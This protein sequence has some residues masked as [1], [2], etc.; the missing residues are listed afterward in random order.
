[1]IT[2]K[3]QIKTRNE[4]FLELLPKIEHLAKWAFRGC[5]R[6]EREEA[7]AEVV[8]HAWIGFLGLMDRGLEHKVYATPLA[9]FAIKRVRSGRCVGCSRNVNDVMSAYAQRERGIQFERLDRYDERRDRWRQI[10][11]EDRHAGPADTAAARIDLAEWF[12]LMP[13]C[14]RRIAKQL[15]DG[16]STGRVA[17]RFQLSN[18]R[19]SQMRREMRRRWDD[20]HGGAMFA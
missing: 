6:E 16:D 13:R 8:A 11:V 20:F 19:I 5:P 1:M 12:R 15:A 4:R 10:L 14:M 7:V 17:R 9:K 2:T 3:G 18:G